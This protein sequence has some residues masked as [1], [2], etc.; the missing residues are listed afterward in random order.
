[1]KVDFAIDLDAEPVESKFKFGSAACEETVTR[2]FRSPASL[3]GVETVLMKP[4]HLDQLMET[5]RHFV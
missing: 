1:V 4:I 5:L 3:E 2:T